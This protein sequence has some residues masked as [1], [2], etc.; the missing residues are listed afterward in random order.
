MKF[1]DVVNIVII[2]INLVVALGA[3]HCYVIE[4]VLNKRILSLVNAVVVNLVGEILEG[5]WSRLAVV[6]E[7]GHIV[8]K[9]LAELLNDVIRLAVTLNLVFLKVCYAHLLSR[10][11]LIDTCK[12]TFVNLEWEEFRRDLTGEC[13]IANEGGCDTADHVSTL[14]VWANCSARISESV[15]YHIVGRGFSVCTRNKNNL[16]RVDSGEMTD[17][18]R[19]KPVCLCTGHIS[20][21]ALGKDVWKEHKPLA[22]EQS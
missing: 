19:H 15:N 5:L 14:K 1:A 2:E 10:D 22:D 12:R 18:I 3:G 7:K 8:V 17:K 11:I 21:S 16:F 9:N 4:L 20:S 13:W 6:E